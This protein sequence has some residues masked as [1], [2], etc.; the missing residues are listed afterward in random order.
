MWFWKI[1]R[2]FFLSLDSVLF[3]FID[4]LYDLL[5]SISRTSILTQGEIAQFAQ[6]I[7]LLLGIFML[8]K[9]SFSLITYVVNPDDFSDKQKGFGK[10]IQSAVISLLMLVLVP[11][12]F[13]MAFNLQTKI[14]EGNILAKLILG[15]DEEADGNDNFLNTAGEEMAFS[16]MLPFFKPNYSI[17]NS[18]GVDLADCIN[19]YEKDDNNNNVFSQTCKD[20]L[21]ESGMETTPLEN[22]SNGITERS[23]GLTFRIEAALST[24]GEDDTEDFL[25]DYMAPISTVVAVVVCL[26]LVTFCIDIGVR[27]V[28]LAFLQLIYPIPVISYMDPKSGKDGLFKKWYQMCF[29]TFLSLFIRLLALYFGVYIISKVGSL[30]VYDVV[31]GSQITNGWVM[32]FVIIGVLMFIK[33]LPKILENLGIKL[34][35]D[36]KFTLNPLKKIEEGA[37]G[38][39][40]II[41][42]AKRTAKGAALAGLAGAAAFGSNALTAASRIRNAE[43]ARGKLRAIAGTFSGGLSAMKR[44]ATAGLKNEKLGKGFTNSYSEAMKQMQKEQQRA[45]D[46]IGKMSVRKAK[47][48]KAMGMQTKGERVAKEQERLKKIQE[49]YKSIKDTAIAVDKDA[50]SLSKQIETI[51]RTAPD[52]NNYDLSTPAGQLAYENAV[53]QYNNAL[54]R[55]EDSLDNRIQAL[56]SGANVINSD[57][58]VN[59]GATNAIA[60]LASDMDSTIP[61]VNRVGHR[62]D[63]D[64]ADITKTAASNAKVASGQA[65]GASTQISSSKKAQ[66]ATSV[67]SYAE[68]KK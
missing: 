14:L 15:E 59:A 50:K 62:I 37:I 58:S 31:T 29:S 35:G 20:A 63:S 4:V 34:D 57:G 19:I 47:A 61:K 39:K 1:M 33:Q 11:Y 5:M 26:L 12:A 25:I 13:Q 3:N 2:R 9:L 38:G 53:Q 6:R 67:D 51:K 23:L 46:G 42:G 28:K 32:I 17:N 49:N 27:N 65:A 30:G 24:T 68:N 64:Y 45:D 36:G 7:E 22:Y 8:F 43:G 18:T 66:K 44:G 10:L 60:N 56:V 52:V 55:V 48:Q 16:V 40:K 54:K 41:G 21:R